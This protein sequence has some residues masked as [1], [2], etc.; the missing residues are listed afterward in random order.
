MHTAASEL[1]RDLLLE[2]LAEAKRG[3]RTV[4]QA[5]DKIGQRHPGVVLLRSI[6]GVGTRTAETMVAYI[7][8]PKRFQHGS[9][10][11]A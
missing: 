8:E 9:R 1:K 7:D 2:E 11:V 6:P 10:A 3:V 4:T 5:L